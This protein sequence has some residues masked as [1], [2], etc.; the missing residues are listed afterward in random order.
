MNTRSNVTRWGIRPARRY[1]PT[2]ATLALTLVMVGCAQVRPQANFAQARRLIAQATGVEAAYDP[3]APLLTNEQLEA[4]FD[5]G[6][7]EWQRGRWTR[8]SRHRLA[9]RRGA[10]RSEFRRTA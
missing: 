10:I 2:S 1:G 8:L 9:D 7:D 6:L 4:T 3:L 5:D